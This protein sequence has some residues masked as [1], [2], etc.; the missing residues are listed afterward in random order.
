MNITMPYGK[1]CISASLPDDADVTVIDPQAQSVDGSD[2]ERIRE[3][4]DH[5]IGTETLEKM[6]TP[7]DRV[8]I[9]IND[10][11]RPGPTREIAAA[12]TARLE[13][14]GVPDGNIRFIVATGSHRAPTADEMKEIL[15]DELLGS[16]EILY[17][18]CRDQSRLFLAGQVQG[19]DVW[20]NTAIREC[21]FLITTGLI[22]PHHTAGF[23]GGRKSILPGITG[24]ETLHIHHSLPLRPYEPSVGK[25][26]NNRFHDVALSAAKMAKVRFMVNAVQDM[27]KQNVAFVAGDIEQ[28]HAAGVEICRRY[29]TVPVSGHA[30]IVI[31]SPGGYPRDSDLYQAQKGLAVAELLVKQGGTMILCARGELGVGEGLFP[32][33]MKEGSSPQDIVDR[34]RREGFN[35]GNNKAFMY[36]RALLRGRIII[37]SEL[38][39]P[40]ELHEMFLDWAPDLQTA[41]DQALAQKPDARVLVLPRAVNLIPEVAE[42]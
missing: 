13:K 32:Q 35:V 29:N 28:A 22:A 17:H 11:T 19:L 9:V 34:Y 37:V 16:Y 24:L 6:V 18:D 26:E 14:A 38:L 30:D 2:A 27:K 41:V 10:H 25:I 42:G 4:L 39:D 23:S 5:P 40:D 3:A 8:L 33:W 7:G 12:V 31:A 15:G 21:T 20:L 1:G 36:A